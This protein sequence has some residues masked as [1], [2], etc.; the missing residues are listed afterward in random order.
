[1]TMKQNTWR[2]NPGQT[3]H[4]KQPF[5]CFPFNPSWW[6]TLKKLGLS[7][8]DRWGANKH[9]KNPIQI[10]CAHKSLSQ[11]LSFSLRRHNGGFRGTHTKT[12]AF[13]DLLRWKA[14]ACTHMDKAW[15]W[16][17]LC[18]PSLHTHLVH[19][20]EDEERKRTRRKAT[21]RR[22]EK[23]RKRKGDGKNAK[24]FEEDRNG[25]LKRKKRGKGKE[26]A[27]NKRGKNE[28]GKRGRK[29]EEEE[30]R[31]NGQGKN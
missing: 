4:F 13:A 1:M 14:K 18:P 8:K 7:T 17:C 6:F 3:A 25:R 11:I 29:D 19:P 16:K 24:E 15:H 2:L 22:E 30:E 31:M 20:S 9:E 28:K 27:W 21:E 23:Q 12:P 10:A 26:N 5:G